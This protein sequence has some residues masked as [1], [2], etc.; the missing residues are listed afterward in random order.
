MRPKHLAMLIVLALIWGASFVFI[1]LAVQTPLAPHNFPPLTLVGIRL[2]L[3]GLLL[4]GVMKV[5]GGSFAWSQWR[6]LAVIGLLNAALPYFLFSWSGVRIDSNLASIYNAT[7]PLWTVILIS[8]FVREERLSPLRSLGIVVGFLGIVYLFS[9]SF[10]DGVL[11]TG[12][13]YVLAEL[14]CVF[15][16]FCYGVSNTWTRSQLK[17]L[18]AMQ[19]ATGQLLFGSLW[20]VPL[21]VTVDQPWRTLSPSVTAVASLLM[22]SVLGSGLAMLLHFHLMTQVG[23]TRTAQVTYLLPISGLFWSW[24]FGEMITP[25]II[26]ALVIVLIGVAIVNG[27]AERLFRRKA[28]V[29]PSTPL[30]ASRQITEGE[31]STRAR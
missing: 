16:A 10:T 24:M 3:A 7:T 25:R 4:Y 5:Q 6:G 1:K 29:V 15:A 9:G 17:N 18:N 2:G 8:I 20:T 11:N 23:A 12:Q 30:V 13:R 27:V 21:I 22:L 31:I 14:A 28:V 19:L 26:G